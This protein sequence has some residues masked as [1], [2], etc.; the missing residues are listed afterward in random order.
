MHSVY[1]PYPQKQ[2]SSSKSRVEELKVNVDIEESAKVNYD[3]VS[4]EEQPKVY[5]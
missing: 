3:N 1:F 4:I 2:I 5:E